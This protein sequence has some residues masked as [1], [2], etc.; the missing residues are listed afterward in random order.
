M[1]DVG[2][3]ITILAG[4][5]IWLPSLAFAF[6]AKQIP[7]GG[8]YGLDRFQSVCPANM[9][10]VRLFDPSLVRTERDSDDDDDSGGGDNDVSTGVVWVAVYRSNNNQPSVMVRDE[11]FHAMNTATSSRESNNQRTTAVSSSSSFL[12]QTWSMLE[13]PTSSDAQAPVA[14]AR[15]L[16]SPDFN[17]CFV[18]DSLRCS[19]RKENMDNSCDGGSEYL[20]AL[21]V[22][23][24]S[25]IL[26]HLQRM[27]DS[28]DTRENNPGTFEGTLRTKATLFSGPILEQRGFEPVE[29][30]SK[31]MATH[32]SKY[33]A[34]LYHYAQRSI[35]TTSETTTNQSTSS[36]QTPVAAGARDRALQIVALLGQLD[37]EAERKAAMNNKN[38]RDEEYDPWASINL[39]R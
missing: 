9:D 25:L 36:G 38:G 34:C 13:I 18:V 23:V 2:V 17:N 30:L 11:F 28:K 19:L 37:P 20:E 35:S 6:T 15:L 33:E 22:A 5:T 12:S 14:V 26:H 7:F 10:A 8:V 29:A 39:R 4:V 27:Q 1:R 31:D 21:S 32:V 3:V 24:D 16:P